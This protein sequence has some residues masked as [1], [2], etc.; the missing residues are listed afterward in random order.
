MLTCHLLL[1]P[2]Y[3]KSY[4]TPKHADTTLIE[5]RNTIRQI[6]VEIL[7]RDTTAEFNM[8]DFLSERVI[9]TIIAGGLQ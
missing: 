4:R 8:S 1:I 2:C 7:T 3:I 6:P 5:T 9:L